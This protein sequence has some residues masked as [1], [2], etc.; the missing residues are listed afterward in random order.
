MH[1]TTSDNEKFNRNGEFWMNILSSDG[2][3]RSFTG[4]ELPSP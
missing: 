1:E 4:L 3:D 2:P